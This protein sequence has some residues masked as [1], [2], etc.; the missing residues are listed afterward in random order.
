MCLFGKVMKFSTQQK[1][2]AHR[3]PDIKPAPGE[4]LSNPKFGIPSQTECVLKVPENSNEA[5]PESSPNHKMSKHNFIAT[6]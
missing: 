6:E 5:A 2:S 1:D 4:S 3:Q